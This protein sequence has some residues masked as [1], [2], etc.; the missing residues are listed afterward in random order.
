M[1]NSGLD[2]VVFTLAEAPYRKI[3][4][5]AVDTGLNPPEDILPPGEEKTLAIPG[6]YTLKSRSMAVLISKAHG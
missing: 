4:A 6:R 5:R 2:S 1:F 3:W